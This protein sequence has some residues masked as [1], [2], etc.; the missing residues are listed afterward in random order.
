M[1]KDT[2]MIVYTVADKNEDLTDKKQLL[3]QFRTF[4]KL[5]E[6]ADKE[7]EQ[8]YDS[9]KRVVEIDLSSY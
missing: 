7:L 6:D 8:L 1:I 2:K 9:S 4:H 5:K 3:S